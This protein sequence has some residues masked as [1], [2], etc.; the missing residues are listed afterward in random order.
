MQK[1]IDTRGGSRR[2]SQRWSNKNPAKE[3]RFTVVSDI[4]GRTWRETAG[5]HRTMFRCLST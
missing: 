2:C 3:F 1:W 5:I 4:G